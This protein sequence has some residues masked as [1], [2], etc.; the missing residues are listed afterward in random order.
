MT[1]AAE[2]HRFVE[3]EARRGAIVLAIGLEGEDPPDAR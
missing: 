3:S 1:E 2:A